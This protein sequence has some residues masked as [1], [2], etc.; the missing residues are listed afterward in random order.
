VIDWIVAIVTLF[1]LGFVL[2]WFLLP[3][4]RVRVEQPK[5]DMLKRV[6]KDRCG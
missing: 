5:F 1:A 6:K 2:I 3:A 4:F